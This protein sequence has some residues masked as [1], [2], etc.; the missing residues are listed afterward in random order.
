MKNYPTDFFRQKIKSVT[1]ISEESI[2]LFLNIMH[3]RPVERNDVLL[4]QGDVSRTLFFVEK[5]YLR[6]YSE[7]DDKEVTLSFTLE[8]NF[9]T[10]LK[11]AR[12]NSPSAFS[13]QVAESGL[14]WE[15]DKAD[16]YRLYEISFEINVFVRKLLE[17]L[18]MIQEEHTSLFKLKKPTERYQYLLEHEP[19]LVKRVPVTHLASYLGITRE[20]LS[21][22]RKP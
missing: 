2:Q 18:L 3:P 6:S 9:A 21:R 4:R 5:G 13:T 15:I 12:Y 22:I 11:S 10:N 8:N 16:L 20:T 17:E 1:D 19:E 14:V 7:K